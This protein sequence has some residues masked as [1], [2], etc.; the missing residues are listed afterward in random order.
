MLQ[1]LL[2]YM[3]TNHR[4]LKEVMPLTTHTLYECLFVTDASGKACHVLTKTLLNDLQIMAN[5]I[6]STVARMAQALKW[7]PQQVLRIVLLQFAIQLQ[8]INM[9]ISEIQDHIFD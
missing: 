3:L 8:N 7:L 2:T 5:A 6:P 9:Y 1:V 4:S